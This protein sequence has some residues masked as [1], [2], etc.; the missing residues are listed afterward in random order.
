MAAFTSEQI[1]GH[2]VDTFKKTRCFD[3][4]SVRRCAQTCCEDGVV[5]TE[6]VRVYRGVGNG[7][8]IDGMARG[9]GRIT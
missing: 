8:N 7:G 5:V 3:P 4:L 6:Y 1:S 9:E 2:N